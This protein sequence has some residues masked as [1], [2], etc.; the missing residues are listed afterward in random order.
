MSDTTPPK[1]SEDKNIETRLEIEHMFA[2]AWQDGVK[3]MNPK[4][5]RRDKLFT[6]K[7]MEIITAQKQAVV[8]DVLAIIGED[9]KLSA[10]DASLVTPKMA[11]INNYKAELRAS[12]QEYRR[13]L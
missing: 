7:T 4:Y 12:L 13:G 11:D 8:D 1:S 5:L 2:S 6:D 9:L 3:H 10:G